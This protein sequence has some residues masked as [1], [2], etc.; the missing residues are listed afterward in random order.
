MIR[1]AL[2]SHASRAE[3]LRALTKTLSGSAPAAAPRPWG[4]QPA[5]TTLLALL[6]LLPSWMPGQGIGQA[7]PQGASAAPQAAVQ[8]APPTQVAPATPPALKAADAAKAIDRSLR[9]LR[10]QQDVGTGGYGNL[11]TTAWVL[12][13]FIESPRAYLVSEGPFLTGALEFLA[14]SQRPDGA[15]A[16]PTD[17]AALARRQSLAA[18]QV[19]VQIQEEPALSASSAVLGFLG[20]SAADLAAERAGERPTDLEQAQA[21]TR[22][23]LRLLAN[24]HTDGLGGTVLETARAVVALSH[25][26]R[27]LAEREPKPAPASSARALPTFAPANREQ[28]VT[29]MQRG[30]RFLLDNGTADGLWGAMGRQD[31]GIT[32]MVVG[33]LLAVPGPLDAAREAR[34]A[35]ALRYLLSLQKPDGSIHAGSLENYVTSAAVVALTR[36]PAPEHAAAVEKAREYLKRLQADEGEGYGRSDIYYGGIGYGD[37]ERPDMSNLQ[38]A[39]EAL[40]AAGLAPEDEA[41]QKALAF[42][43]RSQNRSESNDIALAVG[44]AT[45]RSGEDG[46][47]T[48]GPADSKAGF[49]ELPDGSR[50]PRSY[51]SMTYALLRGYLFAGLKRDDPRVEAAYRWL[52]Q[53]YTLDLNP[54]FPA[55]D[56]P[57][58]PYQGLFYYLTSMAKALDLLGEEQLIDGQGVAHAWRQELSG[59]LIAMQQPDGSWVNPNSPRWWEGNPVLATAYALQALEATLPAAERSVPVE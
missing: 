42:L 49:I 37:D 38:M 58:A 51:G 11:E 20:L 15:I 45:V 30:A 21:R 5:R 10:G 6:W 31:A 7:S 28:V 43:Q 26:Q 46:G 24:E 50:L 40:N 25:C 52:C 17:N 32:G 36:R 19:L 35:Q 2:C 33:A 56:D 41:F 12:R 22:E 14:R 48:Y 44:S 18:A 1:R 29:A 16:A 13:A 8:P 55:G 57:T 34:I 54:G 9:W 23:L 4:G 47:G 39:L 59:R 53:N 27:L 3:P